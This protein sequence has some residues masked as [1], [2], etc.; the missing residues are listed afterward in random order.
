[1]TRIDENQEAIA[2]IR[3]DVD[4]Y[5]AELKAKVEAEDTEDSR[6]TKQKTPVLSQAHWRLGAPQ[7]RITTKQVAIDYENNPAFR[8]FQKNLFTF[9]QQ[10]FP[11]ERIDGSPLKVCIYIL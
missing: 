11:N 1:M 10:V 7:K 3:M 2:C 9:L 6:K 5:D 4:A 8:G